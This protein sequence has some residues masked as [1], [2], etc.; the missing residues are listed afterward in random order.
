MN[1]LKL[2]DKGLRLSYCS[3]LCSSWLELEI[4]EP[5]LLKKETLVEEIELQMGIQSEDQNFESQR[6]TASR[7]HLFFSGTSS[8]KDAGTSAGDY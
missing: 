1:T 3:S 7:G 2:K 5:V 8:F 4:V 6:T